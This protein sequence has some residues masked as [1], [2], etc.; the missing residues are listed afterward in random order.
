MRAGFYASSAMDT[1]GCGLYFGIL[2]GE[3]ENCAGGLYHGLVKR[4]SREACHGAS[5][6]H[7][8]GILLETARKCDKVADGAR[9]Q[10]VSE[11]RL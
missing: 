4:V 5:E 6:Y 2:L 9:L 7:L 3:C 8:Y 11:D 10:D 1:S